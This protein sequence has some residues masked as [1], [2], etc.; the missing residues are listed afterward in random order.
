MALKK[1]TIL[2]WFSTQKEGN[3]NAVSLLCYPAARKK[4]LISRISTAAAKKVKGNRLEGLDYHQIDEMNASFVSEYVSSLFRIASLKCFTALYAR[5]SPIL[6]EEVLKEAGSFLK[7]QYPDAQFEILFDHRQVRSSWIRNWMKKQQLNGTTA[8]IDHEESALAQTSSLIAALCFLSDSPDAEQAK[9]RLHSQF[10]M[11]RDWKQVTPSQIYASRIKDADEQTLSKLFAAYK[12]LLED[13]QFERWMRKGFKDSHAK[14]LLTIAE[15]G[16]P[17]DQI[18]PLSPER[19]D[20][21]YDTILS[22]AK[23]A[24]VQK[25]TQEQAEKQK[26]AQLEAEKES[27][28]GA[29]R[30]STAEVAEKPE[31]NDRSKEQAV[32]ES[33]TAETIDRAEI[34]ETKE[35]NE[36]KIDRKDTDAESTAEKESIQMSALQ[37]RRPDHTQ[38]NQHSETQTDDQ[39]NEPYEKADAA[40]S[41]LVRPAAR[42]AEE[43]KFPRSSALMSEAEAFEYSDAFKKEFNGWKQ[44]VRSVLLDRSTKALEPVNGVRK[45]ELAR[46]WKRVLSPERLE[47][48]LTDRLNAWLRHPGKTDGLHIELYLAET[49]KGTAVI[50]TSLMKELIVQCADVSSGNAQINEQSRRLLSSESIIAAG[51]LEDS[52]FRPMIE[53]IACHAPVLRVHA[54][55]DRLSAA[56][57]ILFSQNAFLPL[58]PLEEEERKI[59]LQ[60]LELQQPAEPRIM[61]LWDTYF[62]AIRSSQS[63][64]LIPLLRAEDYEELTTSMKRVL[65]NLDVP[66]AQL[67]PAARILLKGVRPVKV[68]EAGTVPGRL[69]RMEAGILFPSRMASLFSQV[70]DPAELRFLIGSHFKPSAAWL[71]HDLFEKG[72]DLAWLSVNVSSSTTASKAAELE[73]LYPFGRFPRSWNT[74]VGLTH[75][76]ME[77]LI[78]KAKSL[79]PQLS[80]DELYRSLLAF[81]EQLIPSLFRLAEGRPAP[82]SS[83]KEPGKSRPATQGRSN[84]GRSRQNGKNRPYRR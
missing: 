42:T 79:H 3:Q 40:L 43:K 4:D 32:P 22:A 47:Q 78:E 67:R 1:E 62:N 82:S 59:A 71:I 41:V 70:N 81:E 12:V 44:Q 20:K 39:Q 61:N 19:L 57:R 33:K 66:V 73:K 27:H 49:P 84:T 45:Q 83:S 10:S 15:N 52:Q 5:K 2:V 60:A 36:Q 50:M 7:A 55:A 23:E 6:E 63:D 21:N 46:V 35:T 30:S 8:E 34:T 9:E 26:A 75:E 80:R 68:M 54:S 38:K 53:M 18:E 17:F 37:V 76:M 24:K 31:Q 72:I 16:V 58:I 65:L 13:G 48:E 28:D 64:P 11:A 74:P 25:L 56:Q 51:V 77:E 29:E 14:K 69:E